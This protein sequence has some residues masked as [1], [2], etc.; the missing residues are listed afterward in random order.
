MPCRPRHHSPSPNIAIV[1]GG[2]A[3]FVAGITLR[4][5]LPNAAITLYTA[6]GETMIG[7]QLASWNEQGYPVEHGLHALFGF[8]DHILPILK[9]I[10]AYDNLTRSKEHIFVRERGA[11]HRFDLRTWPAT[12][13]GFTAAEKMK[14]L[15]AAPAIGKLILDVRRKGFG[16]FDTYD[17]RDLRALARKHGVPESVLQSGFFRQFYE[18][19][20]NAPSEL[21]AAVALESIYKIFSKKWHYYFNSPTR[22]SIIAPLQRHFVDH[23]GGVTEF[24]QKLIEVC[25]DTA[26]ARVTRLNFE[27]QITGARSS[28]EADEYILAL[29]L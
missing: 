12:Y 8:Y 23:C 26:G 21:S 5:R 19:A 29:G 25:T 4:E 27:N 3:S 11:I 9:K 2:V 14:S 22:E 1:G 13:R 6:V 16:V 28:V 18:A 7:G 24:N 15:A 17:R 10:G 20:F